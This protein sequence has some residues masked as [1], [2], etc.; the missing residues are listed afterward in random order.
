MDRRSLMFM[1]G[2][3]AIAAALPTPAAA[4]S[5]SLPQAPADRV[6]APAAPAANAAGPNYLFR[7]EFDGPAG[8]PLRVPEAS[9]RELRVG[10]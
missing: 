4:A 6:P 3:G 10:L 7:D 2:F 1:A 8:S 9:F 5:P